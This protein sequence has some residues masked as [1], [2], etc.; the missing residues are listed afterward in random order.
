MNTQ[1]MGQIFL[2]DLLEADCGFTVSAEVKLTFSWVL[3]WALRSFSSLGIIIPC[4]SLDLRGCKRRCQ[5][6]HI[7]QNCTHL[8]R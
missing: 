6:M 3:L 5:R 4:S 2:E 8:T 1:A 7:L